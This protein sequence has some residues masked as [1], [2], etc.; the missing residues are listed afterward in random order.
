MIP[1]MLLDLSLLMG[2]LAVVLAEA[3]GHELVDGAAVARGLVL[4]AA[5]LVQHAGPP[6]PTSAGSVDH[7]VAGV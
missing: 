4:A 6:A 7:A 2:D 3:H 1:C 5:G